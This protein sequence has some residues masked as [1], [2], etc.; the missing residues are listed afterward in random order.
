VEVKK[1]VTEREAQL[2]R[3]VTRQRRTQLRVMRMMVEAMLGECEREVDVM[4]VTEALGE[5]MATARVTENR[6]S[7]VE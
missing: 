7:G 3:R 5:M 6:L 1:M 4:D 2:N